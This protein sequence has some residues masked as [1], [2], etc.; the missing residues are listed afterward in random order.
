MG[1]GFKLG[2]ETLGGWKLRAVVLSDDPTTEKERT[3]QCRRQFLLTRWVV[4]GFRPLRESLTMF[5]RW[6][7][8]PSLEFESH[9]CDFSGKQYGLLWGN[10]DGDKR[11]AGE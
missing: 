2:G 6:S 5:R 8:L 11:D 1:R 4:F 7:S 3:V 9:C 10:A